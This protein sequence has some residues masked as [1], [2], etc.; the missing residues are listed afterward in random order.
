MPEYEVV[1]RAADAVLSHG[2]AQ[3]DLG[4]D[5]NGRIGS[6]ALPGT[7]TGRTIVDAAGLIAV[8]G[9]IDLHVHINT[10]FGG[11]TTRDDFLAGTSAALFG[12]TTTV[13]QFAIPRPGET[14][15]EAVQRTK[16]EARPTAVGDYA[17]HGA[18]VRETFTQSLEQLP[19]LRAAGVGTVKVFSAYTDVLGLTLGQIHRLLER[20]AVQDVTVF[21]HAETDSLDR[22]SVV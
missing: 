8:P 7:L 1:L 12:G 11:T 4:I 6:I 2:R 9:G 22:K 5:A 3:V 20:A 10:F 13:A 17:I 16:T 19:D 18:M 14:S 21:V 15:L